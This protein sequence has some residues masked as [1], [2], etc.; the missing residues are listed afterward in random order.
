MIRNIIFFFILI[1]LNIVNASPNIEIANNFKKINSLKFSFIQK[2]DNNN[3][4]KGEC[5]ILYPKKIFCSYED[6]YNKILVS[7]GKSLIINS[8]KIKNYFRYPLD[9]TPLNFILDKEFI[10]SKIYEL[11]DDK[12]YPFFYVFNVDYKNVS[13]K[14]FF[15]KKNLDLIGWETRDIYQNIIQTFISDIQKNVTVD[16]KIFVIQK[17]IN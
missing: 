1:N 6:I 2:I 9:K 11:K 8:D 7:N 4:E 14:V 3:I 5:I 12:D 13:I 15:D 17:Y 10:I 16:N